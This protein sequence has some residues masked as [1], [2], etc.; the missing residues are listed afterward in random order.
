M[1]HRYLIKNAK[2]MQHVKEEAAVITHLQIHISC[3]LLFF[4][5]SMTTGL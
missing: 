1:S 5:L 4:I 2:E 3:F